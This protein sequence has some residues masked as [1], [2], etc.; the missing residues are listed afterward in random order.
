[1]V[2]VSDTAGYLMLPHQLT[3]GW[4]MDSFDEEYGPNPICLGRCLIICVR[5]ACGVWRVACGVWRVACGVW[6]VACGVWRVACGV[7]RVACGVWRVACGVWRVACGVW[8]VACGVW[9]VACGVWRVACGVWRVACGVWRVACE[10]IF[11]FAN[12][13]LLLPLCLAF[14]APRTKAAGKAPRPGPGFCQKAASARCPAAPQQ[15]G[16]LPSS[17]RP[18]VRFPSI[19]FRVHLKYT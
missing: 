8:R 4:R 12:V 7:W 2:W 1:M 14:P 3:G 19:M 18:T 17:P 15:K 11:L 6:R 10:R 16:S 13:S 5:V 9:R